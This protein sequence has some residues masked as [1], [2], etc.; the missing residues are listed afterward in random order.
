MKSIKKILWSVWRVWFYIVMLIPILV[1]LPFLVASILTVSGYPYF[2]KMSRVWAK[3]VLFGM[4]FYYKVEKVQKL[5]RKKSYM[6]VANH[7]SMTDIML[8]LAVVDNPFVFV[9]KMSLAKIPLFGF[10]YKRTSI[11]VDR[12]SSKS[13]MEVFD[14]A[15]KRI[16]RGLSICIFPEGGVPHDESI[17]LDTFKDGAF[18]LAAEH[19]LPIVPLVFP[20]NKKRL[21]YTFYSGSPGLMRAKMLPPVESVSETGESLDRKELREQVRKIIFDELMEFQKIDASKSK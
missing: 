6:F 9:G 13:R 15:Q 8:M 19:H 11:L 20:D 16:D 1:M 3:C 7:T 4:G 18:R 10:F 2:F 5:D 14:E 21:S 17:I 12:S